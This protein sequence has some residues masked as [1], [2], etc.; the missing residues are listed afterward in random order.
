MWVDPALG[1][2]NNNWISIAA[3]VIA[4][5]AYGLVSNYWGS[6]NISRYMF[7]DKL[8]ITYEIH[9]NAR[10]IMTNL[11][12]NQ[13]TTRFVYIMTKLGRIMNNLGSIMTKSGSIMVH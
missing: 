5:K 10:S 13:F 7:S 4:F 9:T 1:G 11:G 2:D 3:L 6:R 12:L 8:K